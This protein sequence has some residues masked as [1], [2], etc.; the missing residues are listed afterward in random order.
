MFVIIFTLSVFGFFVRMCS[1]PKA[2]LKYKALLYDIKQ[3]KPTLLIKDG[4]FYNGIEGI[5]L[6]VGRKDQHTGDY[7]I[8]SSMIAAV[9]RQN[10][11]IVTAQRG[12]MHMSADDRYMFLNLYN[13]A[14]YEELDKQQG[15]YKTF[16]HVMFAFSEEEIV[17]DMYA[18]N[19]N[20]SDEAC[21]KTVTDAECIS[22]GRQDRFAEYADGYK[23]Q[24]ARFLCRPV[25]R[26]N[27]TLYKK[28]TPQPIEVKGGEIISNAKGSKT[29]AIHQCIERSKNHESVVDFLVNDTGETQK[30]IIRYR[31]EWHRKFTLAVACIIMFFIGAPFGTIIRKG[32]F[33]TPVVISVLLYIFFHI[34]SITGEKNGQ[35]RI[36]F[37]CIRNVVIYHYSFPDRVCADLPGCQ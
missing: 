18:F 10:P 11:V 32:G 23:I 4:V 7:M 33:G 20:R 15:Y 3:Q 5:N 26:I 17:F 2:T 28:Y 36:F 1:I 30:M 24:T 6:R 8:S 13:G 19:L 25:F 22:T 37:S 12:T 31:I 35:D 14:R 16:P 27:D 34:M 29:E 9:A 21:S